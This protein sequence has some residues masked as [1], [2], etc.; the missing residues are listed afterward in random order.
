MSFFVAL[1]DPEVYDPGSALFVLYDDG[2]A[3]SALGGGVDAMPA[4]PL[5]YGF[6]SRVTR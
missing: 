5:G 1:L 6:G 4:S 2:E 3:A